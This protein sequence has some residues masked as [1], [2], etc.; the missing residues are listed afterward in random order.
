MKLVHDNLTNS[1]VQWLLKTTKHPISNAELRK[2][3]KK[4]AAQRKGVLRVDIDVVGAGDEL[5]LQ[6]YRRMKKQIKYSIS[7][8]FKNDG[9]QLI[10]LDIGGKHKNH[11][12]LVTQT[13]NHMHVY[14]AHTHNHTENAQAIS[15]MIFKPLKNLYRRS[16]IFSNLSIF[17]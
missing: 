15:A 7:L 2:M 14:S 17:K 4:I 12:D 10:R 16:S 13:Y 9:T 1:E 8:R 5:V 6:Y 11:G 3:E